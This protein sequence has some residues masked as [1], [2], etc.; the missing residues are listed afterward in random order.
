M[1]DA[2]FSASKDAIRRAGLNAQEVHENL[3]SLAATDFAELTPGALGIIGEPARW[4]HNLGQGDFHRRIGTGAESAQGISSGMHATAEGYVT[5]E[6]AAI[7]ALLAR[8]GQTSRPD[9]YSDEMREQLRSVH[10]PQGQPWKGGVLAGTAVISAGAA[11]RAPGVL[12]AFEEDMKRWK[13]GSVELARLQKMS[14]RTNALLRM[15]SMTSWNAAIACA[16]WMTAMAFDDDNVNLVMGAWREKAER[17]GVIF[18]AGD[19]TNREA[20]ATA[21]EGQAQS[22]ADRKLRDFVTAGIQLADRAVAKAHGLQEA[23]RHLNWLHDTAFAITVEQVCFMLVLNALKAFH[24]GAALGTEIAGR[25]LA[26][27]IIT[28]HG[29]ITAFTLGRTFMDVGEDF[30]EKQ[31]PRIPP[32]DFPMIVV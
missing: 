7:Q 23:V 16:I 3:S 11:W 29:A 28:I 24:P 31:S 4:R 13:P 30:T 17:L 14:G 2:S 32:Q 27:T 8:A 10:R 21:W 25:R 19:P 9:I 5:A 22:A 18:G 20:L 12:R 26:M 1:T 15:A 6:D